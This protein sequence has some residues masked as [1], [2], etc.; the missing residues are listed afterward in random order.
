MFNTKLTVNNIDNKVGEKEPCYRNSII[1]GVAI[2]G[3]FE[4]L[5]QAPD[6]ALLDKYAEAFRLGSLWALVAQLHPLHNDK[7]AIK[8]FD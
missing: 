3:N 6:T 8:G 4:L 7:L 2:N 5:V 1:S